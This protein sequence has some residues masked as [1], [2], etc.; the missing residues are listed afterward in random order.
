MTA[1]LKSFFT[2][3][4]N[5]REVPPIEWFDINDEKPRA[6]I[7]VSP[8]I[9]PNG[10][11]VNY[12]DAIMYWAAREQLTKRGFSVMC[13][14]REKANCEQL[15]AQA[16]KLFI[17][18]AGFVYSSAHHKAIRSA[19]AASITAHN[20]KCCKQAGAIA[21]SAPQTFGPFNPISE[22]ELS[23]QLLEMLD[24]MDSIYARD[25]ISVEYLSQLSPDIS[26]KISIAPD[27]A[28]LYQI[29]SSEAGL[30]LLSRSG[31]DVR[32]GAKP[33]VGL[34]LNRQLYD[35]VPSYLETMKKVITFFKD[36]GTQI[37]LIPH[38]N[39]RYGKKE[40]D[41]QFLSHYRVKQTKVA[42]LSKRKRYSQKA[43]INYIKAV[44]SAIESLDF[45]VSGRFHVAL[46]GLSGNV[47]TVAF[48]W[49]HKYEMLFQTLG[50]SPDDNILIEED[51]KVNDKDEIVCA[52]LEQAWSHREETKLHLTNTI[53][54][55]KQQVSEFIDK[56]VELALNS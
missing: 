19:Q 2:R 47:P 9:Q 43:E 16:A 18:C 10:V 14:P 8:A 6:I 32:K 28:F 17:D 26:P 52:K 48:S 27:L 22:D 44:E 51:L 35:R 38:E 54:K 53:P 4:F 34:T 24:R 25:P 13:L 49:A 42:T 55:V 12:G 11:F 21:I 31:L 3:N 33:I 40:K 23:L 30:R 41:D 50:M 56:S 39:G 20:A 29:D 7:Q 36:K 45:L 15:Q 46:R 37:V 5:K 1:F